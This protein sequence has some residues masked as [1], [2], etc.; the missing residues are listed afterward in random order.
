MVEVGI[1]GFNE[2]LV[3]PEWTAKHIGSGTVL[4]LATP[5]MISLMERTCQESVKPYLGPGEETVGIHVN[6]HH[7]AA[8]PVGMTVRC[9]TEVIEVD[10]RK[11]TFKVAVYDAAGLVGD[12][13]HERFIIEVEKFHGKTEERKRAEG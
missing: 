2:I 12:G 13:T 9:E 3:T 7:H 6:V 1:K 10:R 4:V 11:I 5:M 8:T